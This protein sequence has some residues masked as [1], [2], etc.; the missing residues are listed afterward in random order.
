MEDVGQPRFFDRDLSWLYFNGRILEEARMKKVPLLAKINFLAIYSSNLDEFY[1]VRMP[2]LS[3]IKKLKKSQD[4]LLV[5]AEK[6]SYKKANV[7]IK[8]Q[9]QE[10]GRTMNEQ[11]V[12]ELLKNNIFLVYSQVIPEQIRLEAEHYFFTTLA[13]YIEIRYISDTTFFPEN[14]QL[15][16]LITFA[17]ANEPAILNIPSDKIPRFHT[18]SEGDMTYVVFIDDILR[19]NVGHIFPDR[20]HTGFYSFKITRNAE[21]DLEDEFEGDLREKIEKQIAKR[22]Y[23][24]A[25]RLLYQPDTPK[26][27]LKTMRSLFNLKKKSAMKGGYYH[28]LKDFFKFPISN[29]EWNYHPQVPIPHGPRGFGSLLERLEEK[30]LLI[31]TPYHTYDAILRFF[32][33]AAINKDV[34][35]I[36]I[37]VYRVAKTS[38]ILHALM[39]AA[40]NGKKVTVFVE[41]KAR[42]DEENNIRWAKE[43][44]KAGVHV[45]Y[46]LPNLKVHAKIGLV[47]RRRGK[48]ESGTYFGL[49]STGNLNEITAGV[50]ADHLLLTANQ[51]IS[52]ELAQVFS[53]LSDRNRA[54]HPTSSS[55]KFNHLLVAQFNL[56]ETFEAL[57]DREIA[58]AK[59]GLQARIIIK[60]N[61]LE[62]KGMINKLYE[63]SQAGVKVSLIVRSICRL[64][65][66]V[67]GMSENITVKRI[68]DRYLEHSRV[69]IFHNQ[70]QEVMYLGSADW[71]KRNLY[72]RIEVCFPIYDQ[73]I[74]NE[75]KDLITIQLADDTFAVT[76]NEHLENVPITPTKGVRAQEATYEYLKE[77]HRLKGDF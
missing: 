34:E 38:R 24:L 71:M 7:L 33:E 55:Y 44:K 21:I 35:E 32:N 53:I 60:L 66:G 23:G 72:K 70:A 4:P 30:D 75:I 58:N 26:R 2:V 56:V 13:A 50:Y 57:V 5:T 16:A 40:R 20:K 41:L 28:N 68:V 18:I 74:K 36:W 12:P 65:P 47:K 46:S 1:R 62:E 69:F 43:L 45:L 9:Q 59:N 42:F 49:L 67:Q 39:S 63:A 77:K 29:Q 37:S 19:Q 6:G 27:L 17:G 64:I 54:L 14:N 31:N 61:N 3:A 22:D 48:D 11:I 73:D 10:Y 15:Y 8:S 52:K 51:H 25:T 76:L